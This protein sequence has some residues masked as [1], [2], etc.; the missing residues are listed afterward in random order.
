MDV[1]APNGAHVSAAD[2]WIDTYVPAPLPKP[3][4]LWK[5]GL[6]P[7]GPH[8]LH[9]RPWDFRLAPRAIPIEV[10]PGATDRIDVSLTRWIHRPH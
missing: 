6:L 2:I 8:V 5:S 1:H 9:V 7:P 3:G 4:D 10:R